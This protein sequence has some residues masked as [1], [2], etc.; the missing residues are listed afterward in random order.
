MD[1][2]MGARHIFHIERSRIIALA[3]RCQEQGAVLKRRAF[4]LLAEV[5]RKTVFFTYDKA[6]RLRVQL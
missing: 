2:G 3:P 4:V 6:R 1:R 5:F